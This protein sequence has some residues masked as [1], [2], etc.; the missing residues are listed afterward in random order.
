[1]SCHR[2]MIKPLTV[3]FIKQLHELL[4]YGTVDSRPGKVFP[5]EISNTKSKRKETFIAPPHSINDRLSN[6]IAALKGM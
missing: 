4:M 2:K 1:M 3:K 6:Y 5:G